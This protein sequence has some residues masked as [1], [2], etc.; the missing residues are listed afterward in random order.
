MQD[1]KGNP[2]Q[3]TMGKAKDVTELLKTIAEGRGVK[4][5]KI[6]LSCDGGCDPPKLLVMG[7]ILDLENPDLE[8]LKPWDV[9]R[10]ILIGMVD[11]VPEN[12][13]N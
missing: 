13:A 12:N 9:H 2:L 4:K 7:T 5:E 3:R 1:N 6:V 8:G 10:M 11:D